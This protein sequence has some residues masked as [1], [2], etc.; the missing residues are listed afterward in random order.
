MLLKHSERHD[1]ERPL[2]RGSKHHE[3]RCAVVV[4]LQPVRGCDAPA[5]P[6]HKTRELI[7]RHR[8]AEVV[9]YTALMLEEL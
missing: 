4:G 8:S 5:V 3:R 1:F 9:A 7:L 6:G 2:M